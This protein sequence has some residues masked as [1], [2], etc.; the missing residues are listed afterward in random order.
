MQENLWRAWQF[1]VDAYIGRK[2]LRLHALPQVR[3]YYNNHLQRQFSIDR[4]NTTDDNITKICEYIWAFRTHAIY[5]LCIL[6]EGTVALPTAD[7]RYAVALKSSSW[8]KEKERTPLTERTNLWRH[9]QWEN[10]AQSKLFWT[11]PLFPR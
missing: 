4:T 3:Q 7:G 2:Y 10:Y 5:G 1:K 11:W 8:R 9:S 6:A